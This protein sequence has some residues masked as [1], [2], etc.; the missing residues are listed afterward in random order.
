MKFFL[1]AFTLCLIGSLSHANNVGIYVQPTLV[2]TAN[3]IDEA[4][5]VEIRE[6]AN[7]AETLADIGLLVKSSLEA[8]GCGN[9]AVANVTF[10]ARRAAFI[11]S[12]R[13]SNCFSADLMV[14]G[15]GYKGRLECPRSS[16]VVRTPTT[17]EYEMVVFPESD[18]DILIGDNDILCIR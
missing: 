1:S 11:V 10:E 16:S 14:R 3:G 17:D 8:L 9:T 2:Y 18:R 12:I 5:K 13:T 6:N 4:A 15:N 7:N